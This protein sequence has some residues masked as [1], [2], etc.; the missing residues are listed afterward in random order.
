MP[1]KSEYR[2]TC[3]YNEETCPLPECWSR[4]LLDS[5]RENPD[6]RDI[7][8]EYMVRV[9]SGDS[10]ATCLKIVKVTVNAKSRKLK[11]TWSVEP[12]DLK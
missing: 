9:M 1:D 4:E 6:Y 8:Q 11:A 12:G 2:Y 3:Q 10:V 7:I 5:R